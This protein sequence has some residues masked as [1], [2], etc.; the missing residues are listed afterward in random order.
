M[1]ETA[2]GSWNMGKR[3]FPRRRPRPRSF[4]SLVILQPAKLK[5]TWRSRSETREVRPS[6]SSWLFYQVLSQAFDLL[7]KDSGSVDGAQEVTGK[8]KQSCPWGGNRILGRQ[9]PCWDSMGLIIFIQWLQNLKK[10]ERETRGRNITLKNHPISD[11]S[12]WPLV[13]SQRVNKTKSAETNGLGHTDRFYAGIP[14]AALLTKIHI[15]T[16]FLNV[17]NP[18]FTIQNAKWTLLDVFLREDG[19]GKRLKNF[20]LRTKTNYIKIWVLT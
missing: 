4:S 17:Y 13:S 7:N 12:N 10:R 5:S 3:T 2:W 6:R 14:A 18:K 1:L 19:K 16:L 8:E 11:S 20:V 9:H 15:H